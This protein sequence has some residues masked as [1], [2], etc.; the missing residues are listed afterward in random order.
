MKTPRQLPKHLEGIVWT[1]I[2]NIMADTDPADAPY[3]AEYVRRI[4]SNMSQE[5]RQRTAWD[6]C[7]NI[8]W[9]I[10][11]FPDFDEAAK[12][13][14]QVV[15]WLDSGE[16]H[17]T[18]EPLPVGKTMATKVWYKFIC[19]CLRYILHSKT[20][21]ASYA[22]DVA[23]LYPNIPPVMRFSLDTWMQDN[24]E[25]TDDTPCR[26]LAAALDDRN[27]YLVT[28]EATAKQVK[29]WIMQK[30]ITAFGEAMNF[31]RA[32]YRCFL[33]DGEYISLDRYIQSPATAGGVI[34]DFI[35]NVKPI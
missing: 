30:G 3:Y 24:I 28:A 4:A 34:K 23:R 2:R 32:T 21:A 22:D 18:A 17:V 25:D 14:H 6:I 1:A 35:T 8:D 15:D 19:H 27:H 31:P 29:E 10:D 16:L 7:Q 26:R 5:Q 20:Y 12:T 13:W 9:N 11:M 33:F